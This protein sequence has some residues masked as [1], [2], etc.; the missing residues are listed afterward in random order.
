MT[1][2][3][4]RSRHLQFACVYG[5]WSA[6]RSSN[7]EIVDAAEL[8]ACNAEPAR[9]RSGGDQQLVEANVLAYVEYGKVA[10]LHPGQ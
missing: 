6:A 1:K 7:A 9:T 4:T 10:A 3:P 8:F 5:L 2:R